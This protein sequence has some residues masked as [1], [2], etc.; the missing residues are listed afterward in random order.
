MG[1]DERMEKLADLPPGDDIVWPEPRK[2]PK[3][4]PSEPWA[5]EIRKGESARLPDWV[6]DD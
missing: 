3:E 4:E 1:Y 5:R 6:K 2:D